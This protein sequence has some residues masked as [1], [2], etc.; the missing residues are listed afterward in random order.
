MNI[1]EWLK[2]L[3][4][5]GERPGKPRD[6]RDSETLWEIQGELAHLEPRQG[7][8]IV[9]V[10][11]LLGRVAQVDL[12]IERTE[13]TE[14]EDI[15][16]RELGLPREQG[17]LVTRMA[18]RRAQLFGG[19][20]NFLVSRELGELI[21]RPQKIALVRCLFRVAAADQSIS[22]LEDNEI[23][24]IASELSLGRD[25]VGAIRAEFRESL[26]VLKNRIATQKE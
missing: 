17:Q 26:A 10:A 24:Q 18:L 12:N 16:V 2:N 20:D 15:L 7:R 25:E 3:A 22:L 13:I 5:E 8:I 21:E 23:S 6:S 19:T 14:I 11:F 9:C 4:Q 1:F